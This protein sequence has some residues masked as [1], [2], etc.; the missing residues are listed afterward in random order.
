MHA[1]N[2]GDPAIEPQQTAPFLL[3]PLL[4]LNAEDLD[5][6]LSTEVEAGPWAVHVPL[7]HWIVVRPARMF[8]SNWARRI[9]CHMPPSAMRSSA[10][11]LA[12]A[13]AR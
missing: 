6:L 13:A 2:P 9:A 3:P 8:W 4:E 11:R 10:W 5:P 1:H 12:R 7:V